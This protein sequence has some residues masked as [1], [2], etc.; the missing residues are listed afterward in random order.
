V[1]ERLHAATPLPGRLCLIDGP[2]G[3]GKTALLEALAARGEQV[4]DLEALAGHRGSLFGATA[5]GQP[6]QKLFESLLLDVLE[7]TDP[8]RPIFAE[9]ESSRI[10]NLSI[11]PALWVAM[12]GAPRIRLSAPLEWRVAHILERYAWITSEPGALAEAIGRLP[13]HHSKVQKAAWLQM[14]EAGALAPLVAGLIGAH[15]DPA[16]ARS[17]ARREGTLL[18]TIAVGPG[19]DCAAAAEAAAA[20]G[21]AGEPEPRAASAG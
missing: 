3:V 9:A 2:T 20:L 18:G 4:L 5:A 17:A 11:P 12:A 8:G 6:S 19:T 10:G 16:Y 14:A 7:R 1:V 21:V 13:S 15:Y